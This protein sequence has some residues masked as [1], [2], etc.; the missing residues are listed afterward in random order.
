VLEAP[1]CPTRRRQNNQSI[2]CAKHERIEP[3]SYSS[4]KKLNKRKVYPP[5][6]EVPLLKKNK[7]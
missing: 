7:E 3:K 4:N 2:E 5:F 6:S 1:K